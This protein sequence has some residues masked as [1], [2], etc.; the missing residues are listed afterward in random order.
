MLR[1]HWT[2]L[3]VDHKHDSLPIVRCQ[4]NEYDSVSFG[5]LLHAVLQEE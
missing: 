2:T 5:C 1:T 3:W 4:L